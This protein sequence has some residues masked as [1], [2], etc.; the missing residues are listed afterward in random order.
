MY[1]SSPPSA[2]MAHSHANM[3]FLHILKETKK[4]LLDYSRTMGESRSPRQQAERDWSWVCV[5]GTEGSRF[6]IRWGVGGCYRSSCCIWLV[7][8]DEP[9][10]HTNPRKPPKM[11]ASYKLTQQFIHDRYSDT[12]MAHQVAV[13]PP[14]TVSFPPR[15]LDI[16]PFLC[17]S[18]L[19]S[20]PPSLSMG[21]LLLPFHSPTIFPSFWCPP[22]HPSSR[23]LICPPQHV[24]AFHQIS[25]KGAEQD[26]YVEAKNTKMRLEKSKTTN[27]N[28]LKPALAEET[29]INHKESFFFSISFIFQS[30]ISSLTFCTYYVSEMSL[31]WT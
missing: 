10:L 12:F 4:T 19:Q 2:V 27:K 23:A 25:F 14:F 11:A 26:K 15:Y 5:C 9:K 17:P 30:R 6:C 18:T 16:P 1:A 8:S 3:H 21:G 7:S 28:K 24:F 20:S 22:L 31:F 29:N 13:L